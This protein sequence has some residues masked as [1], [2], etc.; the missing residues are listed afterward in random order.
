MPVTMVSFL[1]AAASIAGF[2]FT[3]GFYSKELVFDGALQSGV[4]FYAVALVGAFFTAVSFLKL[5]HAAF[6]G[7]TK[8]ALKDVKEAPAAMSF[9][10]ES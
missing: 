7:K 6:F 10:R 2:P 8:P 5:G 4:V 3:N 9:Y 1:I